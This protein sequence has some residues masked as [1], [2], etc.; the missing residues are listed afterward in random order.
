MSLDFQREIVERSDGLDR[1]QLAS[2]L[3]GREAFGPFQGKNYIAAVEGAAIV[4]LP[5][6]PKLKTIGVLALERPTCR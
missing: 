3:A 1:G 2:M 6:L 4:K 5:V